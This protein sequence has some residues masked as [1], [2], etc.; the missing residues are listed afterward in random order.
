MIYKVLKFPRVVVGKKPATEEIITFPTLEEAQQYVFDFVMNDARIEYNNY[1]KTALRTYRDVLIY[2]NM[3][4]R[5]ECK[6]EA[7]LMY[8]RKYKGTT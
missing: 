4:F 2:E 3:S 1:R 7:G 5:F 8:I 6:S